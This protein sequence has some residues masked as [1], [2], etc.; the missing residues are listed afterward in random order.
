MKAGEKIEVNNFLCNSLSP[1]RSSL[2]FPYP[3]LSLSHTLE[4]H[5]D[6]QKPD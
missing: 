5:H 4:K 3:F 1:S 2:L 6:S